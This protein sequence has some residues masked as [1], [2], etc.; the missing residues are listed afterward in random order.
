MSHP[1]QS[2]KN[3]QVSKSRVSKITHGSASAKPKIHR[4]TGGRVPDTEVQHAAKIEGEAM[5]HRA[6]RPARKKG[7]R[8]K[9]ASVN[10][11]VI[12][13]PSAA[14]GVPGAGPGMPPGPPPMAPAG[15][16]PGVMAGGPPGMPPGMRPPDAPPS[17]LPPMP[18]RKSGGRV[19]SGPAWSEGLENGT[20]V[21]H[22]PGK[23]QK[24]LKPSPKPKRATGGK[25]GKLN[26]PQG[27]DPATKLPGGAGGGLGRLAKA[28]K[29]GGK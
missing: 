3:H 23:N 28:R 13:A 5:P 4:A 10:I 9:G 27:V 19:K 12:S 14:P 15:P 22:D 6:D 16:P 29:Y 17:G 25:V 18:G 20:P 7:G 24:L 11:N 8:V 1:Y 21:E 26:A 2:H